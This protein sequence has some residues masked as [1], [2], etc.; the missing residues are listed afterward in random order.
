[1]PPSPPFFPCGK[2]VLKKEGTSVQPR[3]HPCTVWI[4]AEASANPGRLQSSDHSPVYT[5]SGMSQ[6]HILQK[7]QVSGHLPAVKPTPS[8]RHSPIHQ[9]FS[10][11]QKHLPLFI[12]FSPA[13]LGSIGSGLTSSFCL[14]CLLCFHSPLA[15]DNP[16]LVLTLTLRKGSRRDGRGSQL[17]LRRRLRL[18]AS[19][20]ESGWV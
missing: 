14:P 18:G 2:I 5:D 7:T 13:C 17:Q 4:R 8:C 19:A 6:V 16:F 1:L 20:P 11:T 15:P 10:W 12:S 3:S 9:I